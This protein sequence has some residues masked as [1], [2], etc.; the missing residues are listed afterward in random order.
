MVWRQERQTP[1]N[2][3][4]CPGGPDDDERILLYPDE[5]LFVDA[6]SLN[7]RVQG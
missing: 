6:S 2:L 5:N 4:G 7:V 1:R 3:V